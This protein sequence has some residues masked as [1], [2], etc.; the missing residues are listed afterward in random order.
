MGEEL[1]RHHPFLRI[2]RQG[3]ITVEGLMRPHPCMRNDRQLTVA[4][5]RSLF[6]PKP[7]PFLKINKWLWG[8]GLDNSCLLGR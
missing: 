3:M 5:G 7:H 8:R 2:D 4:G 6:P 1:T